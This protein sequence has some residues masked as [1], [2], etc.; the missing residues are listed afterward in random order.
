MIFF[1]RMLVGIM[2]GKPGHAE[3][4]QPEVEGCLVTAVEPDLHSARIIYLSTL[5][6]YKQGKI[7]YTRYINVR[8]YQLNLFSVWN[9]SVKYCSKHM[10]TIQ[11]Y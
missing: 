6:K 10:F 2:V 9:H 1:L 8:L 4:L 7:L 11:K 5:V 3:P